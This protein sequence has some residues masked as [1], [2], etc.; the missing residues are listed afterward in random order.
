M[1]DMTER[2]KAQGGHRRTEAD[3]VFAR[4]FGQ[5][6]RRLRIEAGYPTPMAMAQALGDEKQN[7]AISALELGRYMAKPLMVLELARLLNTSSS[8]LLGDAD[9]DSDY[10]AGYRAALADIEH[11][12]H[13]SLK[14]LRQRGQQ[15]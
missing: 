14:E 3:R 4:E 13:D 12:V 11:A 2:R 6:L 5:R 8:V 7:S 1:T 15:S 10:R 9:A